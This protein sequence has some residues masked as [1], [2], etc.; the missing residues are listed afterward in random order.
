MSPPSSLE[1]VELDVDRSFPD[2]GHLTPAALAARL[3]RDDAMIVLLDV[4]EPAE[5]AVSHLA[6]AARVDPNASAT[7]IV[8]L[9]G[10]RA[11]GQAVILY[12]SV[13]QRSSRL[14]RRA[15]SALR[16]T[17][18]VE[19]FNLRGGIFAWRNQARPVIDIAGATPYI[20]PYN[21]V[22]GRLLHRA[23]LIAYQPR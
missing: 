5:F 3:A 16:A 20:H 22:W 9:V 2:V 4:R 11:R 13:G 21:Q 10:T 1:E 8:R 19:V 18:A 7:E 15:Q 6:G 12:C 14:A 23:E 17:G